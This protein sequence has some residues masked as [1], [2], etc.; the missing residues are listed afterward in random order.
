MPLARS[1]ASTVLIVLLTAGCAAVVENEP[2]D[3]ES[4]SEGADAATPWVPGTGGTPSYGGGPATGGVV[5]TGG[6]VSAGG[7]VASGGVTH[8]GGGGAAG[9]SM[10][11]GGAG[12]SGGDG[13]SGA[14]F[15]GGA[16]GIGVIGGA[17]GGAPLVPPPT[18]VTTLPPS[19]DNPPE[20]PAVAPENPVGD[21][22]GLPVY[23]SCSWSDGTR[24]YSC[25]CDW[26]HWLCV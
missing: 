19:P 9:G 16:G 17:G 13:G 6:A 25:V 26:Y 8:S 21:C 23:L 4:G 11:T 5:A 12:A 1:H 14:T 7:A 3:I 10:P 24:T 15:P 20:C 18:D 22:L 2:G